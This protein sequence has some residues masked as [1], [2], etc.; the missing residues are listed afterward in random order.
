MTQRCIIH[1]KTAGGQHHKKMGGARPR[2]ATPIGPDHHQGGTS[3]ISDLTVCTALCQITDLSQSAAALPSACSEQ[4]LVKYLVRYLSHG[5]H[6][7]LQDEGI[8]SMDWPARS[9]DLNPIEQIFGIMSRT[10]HQRHVSPQTVQELADALVQVWEEIPQETIRHLN[11]SMP[12]NLLNKLANCDDLA[13]PNSEALSFSRDRDLLETYTYNVRQ[14][15]AI[16]E[17]MNSNINVNV[18]N[19]S[20]LVFTI[21][22]F[23]VRLF[24]DTAFKA[25]V[26]LARNSHESLATI[27]GTAACTQ[28][29][30]ILAAI[31]QVM[32]GIGLIFTTFSVS[33][34]S[35]IPFWGPIIYIIAGSLTIA[36]QAKPS[37]CLIKGSLSMNILTIT[38]SVIGLVLTCVDLGIIWCYPRRLCRSRI[39][40][41]YLIDSVLIVT[42]LLLFCLSISL[43]VFG[44]RALNHASSIVPQVFVIQNDVVIS[45]PPSVFSTSAPTFPQT[46]PPP[47]ASPPPYTDQIENNGKQTA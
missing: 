15:T 46:Q 40:G 29:V 13:V 27:P 47:P 38:F 24:E 20:S 43:S 26:I 37:I 5:V 28:I 11:S 39:I 41:G 33:L 19:I 34:P 23:G 1:M 10:I 25:G 4:A 6:Y 36:A 16:N 42:N 35:G 30:L 31:L 32:V 22:E 44:C 2:P 7:F 14:L 9:P 17:Y 3:Q 18:K 45:M 12:S 8:D 21:V